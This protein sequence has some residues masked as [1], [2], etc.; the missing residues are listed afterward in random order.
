MARP[1]KFREKIQEIHRSDPRLLDLLALYLAIKAALLVVALLGSQLLPFNWSLYN[2]NLW[3]DIQGLPAWFRPFN[4]WDTQHYLLLAQRGYGVNPM[5]NAFY[6]LFPYL[7]KAFTPIFFGRPLIAA[8]V[9]SNLF[10]LLVPV[11]MYKLCCLHWTNEQAYRS[12]ILLLAFPTAF[13]L[14]VAYTESLYLSICLMAFYYVFKGDI[15]KS[16]VL[17][18][19]LPLVRSQGLLLVAPLG[20]L[21]LQAVFQG[22]DSPGVNFMRASRTLLPPVLA[23]VLGMLAYFGFCRWQMGGYF[24]GLTAQRLWIAQNSLANMFLPTRWF[25]ANFVN[26][27]LQLHGYT[28]SVIDRA[29]FVLCAPILIGVYRTQNRA[30]FV[31][32]ALTLLVPAMS[33]TFMSYTRSLL[34]VFPLFIYLGARVR[35]PEYLAVPMFAL[36]VLL[37]LLHT[38]GYWVA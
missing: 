17:C 9:V 23:S 6:P 14:S 4:T 19:L 15:V 13:Y 21:F 10:S 38:G 24:D 5:S 7:I 20:I 11:Y 30:L 22:K 16:S 25:M 2:A 35:R 34:V 33:G 28:N 1:A 29:A 36:Q 3:L 37:Y 12:T 8:Y 27:S 32:A 18:F 26:I 31:Y